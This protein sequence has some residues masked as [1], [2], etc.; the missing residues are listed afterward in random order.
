VTNSSSSF[1]DV[2]ILFLRLHIFLCT[3]VH[4]EC[5]VH[6]IF[7]VRNY[8]DCFSDRAP[9]NIDSDLLSSLV[10]TCVLSKKKNKTGN[11]WLEK[12]FPVLKHCWKAGGSY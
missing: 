9:K 6:Q 11:V 7:T 2:S 12:S 10:P 4:V 5:I 3:A 1:A 8:V